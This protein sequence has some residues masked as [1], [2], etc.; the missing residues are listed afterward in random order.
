M[1]TTH[2]L[3]PTALLA[4]TSLALACTHAATVTLTPS[5]S[6]FA[7]D[8]TWEDNGGGIFTV[9]TDASDYPNEVWER[10]VESGKWSDSAP[11]RTLESGGKYFAY[12]DI[13]SAAFGWDNDYLYARITVVDGST[14]DGSSYDTGVGY[15]GHYYIY[16]SQSSQGA[17]GWIMELDSG[18]SLSGSQTN[19]SPLDEFNPVSSSYTNIPTSLFH[20]AN[21]DVGG[22]GL[23]NTFDSTGG[24][25][26]DDSD[27]FKQEITG[28]DGKAPVYVRRDGDTVHFALKFSDVPDLDGNYLQN[29]DPD[30]LLRFG[31]A[32][33]NPS[34]PNGD[35]LANDEFTEAQGGDT[36]YDT[37]GLAIP[38]PAS[39][40]LLILALASLSFRRQRQPRKISD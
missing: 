12:N 7:A 13:E 22:T 33:S 8:Y 3:H 31:V 11:T 4:A 25:E 37:V 38:E 10:P 6:H 35:I 14:W 29:M 26:A 20:D 28:N 5:Y 23:N 40:T 9:P 17:N 16:F 19:N 36:T 27:G 34:A 1:K 39:S 21:G 2:N 18:T 24:S 15:K 30:S 32:T